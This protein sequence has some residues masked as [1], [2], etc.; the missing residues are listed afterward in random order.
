[1]KKKTLKVCAVILALCVLLGALP[2]SAATAERVVRFEQDGLL[3]YGSESGLAVIGCT[4][5]EIGEHINIP[6]TVTYQGDAYTV[7]DIGSGA[8]YDLGSGLSLQTVTIPASVS[9]IESDAFKNCQKLER[10]T[11]A[12]GCALTEL[13]SEVFAECYSLRS[14]NIPKGVASIGEKAFYYC[15]LTSVTLPDSLSAVGDEA[16]RNTLL[17][18]VTIPAGVESIGAR[19]FDTCL[20]LDTAHFNAEKTL[21]KV[22]YYGSRSEWNTLVDGKDIGI[23][24]AALYTNATIT[25]DTMG[26]GTAPDPVTIRPFVRPSSVVGSEGPYVIDGE[27]AV[28]AWYEDE[29]LTKPFDFHALLTEDVTVYAD[30]GDRKYS[31]TVRTISGTTVDSNRYSLNTGDTHLFLPGTK[32]T[33]SFPVFNFPDLSGALLDGVRMESTFFSNSSYRFTMPHHDAVVT[34]VTESDPTYSVAVQCEP[35][36]GG[37]AFV[38]VSG[39]KRV[40]EG[41]KVILEQWTYDGYR[42]KEWQATGGVTVDDDGTFI[43]PA[44]EVTVTAVFEPEHTVIW[45]NGDGSRLASAVT[46]GDEEEP[47]TDLIPEKADEGSYTYTFERWEEGAVS[48]NTKTYVP[49]FSRTLKNIPLWLGDTQITGDNCGDIPSVTDGKASFDPETNTLTLDHIQ[50]ISG[51]YNDAI[52]YSDLDLLTIELKGENRFN[53]FIQQD[54]PAYDA[55]FSRDLGIVTGGGIV[56]TDGGSG[57]LSL[58]GFEQSISA[59]NCPVTVEGGALSISM[60]WRHFDCVDY[61]ETIRCSAM[62]LCGGSLSING[63]YTANGNSMGMSSG[64]SGSDDSYYADGICCDS[65]RM[66][67]GSF[68]AAGCETGVGTHDIVIEGGRMDLSTRFNSGLYSTGDITIGGLDTDISIRSDHNDAV[69][70]GGSLI[71]T[72]DVCVASPEG[73]YIAVGRVFDG[74]GLSAGEVRI[75]T[76]VHA[77]TIV[78][79]KDEIITVPV[80]RGSNFFDALDAQ[81][82]FETLSA[83]DSDDIVFRDLAT[84]PLSEFADQEAFSDDAY[85]LLNTTVTSDMTVYACFYTKIKQV[86]L[87]VERPVVGTTVTITNDIQTPSPVLTAEEGAHYSF[88]TDADYQYSQWY[89]KD[90]DEY[91][92]FEGAFEEGGTYYVDCLLAPDFGYW[93]DDDTVVTANGA[94]VEEASGRMSLSVTLSAKAVFPAILGDA[95][96]DGNVTVIDATWIQRYLADMKVPNA[97]NEAAADADADGDV[98]I[99]DA[100]W[101]QR[102][103]AEMTIPYPIGKTI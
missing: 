52:L 29:A 45:L 100:T 56:F 5:R 39:G 94:T 99:I 102:W 72:D 55:D 71:L 11:F 48:D 91:R 40:I 12:A 21:K 86:T 68:S 87:T 26:Q 59:D 7:T 58:E 54:K 28:E 92:P 19:A 24:S 44:E 33:V 98:S 3:Y 32:V 89:T 63:Y 66:T 30:W 27:K 97:F 50:R 95:D 4:V 2:L 78:T 80:R 77:V 57:S 18:S 84:K 96:G 82:V 35:E 6:E 25:F 51:Q 74:N 15:A 62:N 9:V 38:G 70:A 101:I 81:G 73:A 20:I 75:A 8:F 14:V 88:Y 47:V 60:A 90:N 10:V 1:M 36:Q 34:I 22:V 16:F 43:M 85:A 13:A 69:C 64:T 93:M 42:F 17:T 76:R 67:G 83:M 65:F 23:G 37:N 79:G 49:V 31:V 41:E 46:Y 103:L 61:D 53:Y